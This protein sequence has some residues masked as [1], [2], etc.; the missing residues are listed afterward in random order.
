MNDAIEDVND[1]V[2][3]LVNLP[4]QLLVFDGVWQT[5]GYTKSPN[6]QT[7]FE[8]Y[9][10][11]EILT[12]GLIDVLNAIKKSQEIDFTKLQIAIGVV[13]TFMSS[14]KQVFSLD[15]FM[16]DLFCAY[17]SYLKSDKSEIFKPVVLKAKN[18]LD[19]KDFPIFMVGTIRLIS[20]GVPGDFLLKSDAIKNVIEESPKHNQLEI[21]MPRDTYKKYLELLHRNIFGGLGAW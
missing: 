5:Y 11:K 14:M 2:A 7:P 10:A 3:Y 17:E 18:T 13:D 8:E 6:I 12:M 15:I 19:E 16:E 21:S 9:I 4:M 20:G 1:L